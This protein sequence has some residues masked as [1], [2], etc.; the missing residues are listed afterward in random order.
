MKPDFQDKK[1]V[2]KVVF[3]ILMMHQQCSFD[4]LK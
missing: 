1:A 4:F 2:N 3:Q